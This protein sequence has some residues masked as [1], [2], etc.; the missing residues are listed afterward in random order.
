MQPLQTMGHTTPALYEL[1][2][3]KTHPA[4]FKVT[5]VHFLYR[6]HIG[7]ASFTEG[8]MKE[9]YHKFN[10]LLKRKSKNLRDR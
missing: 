10:S 3:H 1:S 2:V 4:Y 8:Q 9:K 7:L 5:N 6:A